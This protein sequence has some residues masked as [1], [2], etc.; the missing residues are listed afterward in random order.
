MLETDW[1]G[2]VVLDILKMEDG[3]LTLKL[4]L[5][6]GVWMRKLG[7]PGFLF[8]EWELERTGQDREIRWD[9]LRSYLEISM[10]HS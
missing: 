8:E 2:R 3:I 10:T 1:M 6:L 5:E 4:R 9:N 7:L